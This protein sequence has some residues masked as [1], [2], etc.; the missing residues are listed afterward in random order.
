MGRQGRGGE[1]LLSNAN[2]FK[3]KDNKMEKK[4]KE[5]EISERTIYLFSAPIQA[6]QIIK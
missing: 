4:G 5:Q 2:D 6:N 1:A 3:T